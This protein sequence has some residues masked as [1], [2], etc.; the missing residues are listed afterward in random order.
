M[1]TLSSIFFSVAMIFFFV[2]LVFFEIGTR[3]LRKAGNPKVYDKRGIR[4]LV[5]SIILA[6]VSLLFAFI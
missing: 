5:L 1:K 2:S 6:G 3:K 4:F